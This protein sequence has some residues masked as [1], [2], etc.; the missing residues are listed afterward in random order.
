MS[1]PTHTVPR[2]RSKGPDVSPSLGV[3]FRPQ[4]PPERLRSV[5]LAADEVGL[6]ELWLW[7][8]CFLEG[9]ISTAAMALAWTERV[10]IGIGLL[11]VPLRN[12]ALAAMELAT[13]AR[14]F[15]DRLRIGI[16]PGVQSWMRQVGEGVDSPL[17]L[18]RENLEAIRALLAGRSVSVEGRYVRLDDVALDW[19]P[20]QPPP[21]LVG[22]TGPRMLA[23]SGAG[24][25]GT[26]LTASTS[27]DRLR[28][29]RERI[30][31]GQASVG[32]AEPHPIVLYAMAGTDPDVLD[33]AARE[34]PPAVEPA[35]AVI[36][37]DAAAFAAGIR[38]RAEAGAD[39]VV[40]QPLAD[41]TDLEDFIR[42]AADEVAPL[43]RA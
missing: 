26:I 10:R 20:P 23:L 35:D 28:W 8:D 43:L 24:S 6:D 32:R 40:L 33:R 38:A 16:G 14:A 4:L 12:P 25:D 11:P 39:A 5:V 27:V 2:A 15:P 41:A 30:E 18:L 19:P 9:G 13:L 42:F 22:A 31:E 7:E 36:S 37:G 21:I 29:A 3:V 17:T 1:V 34:L